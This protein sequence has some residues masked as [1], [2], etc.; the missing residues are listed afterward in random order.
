M[1][2]QWHAIDTDRPCDCQVGIVSYS[3]KC[4][5]TLFISE[6]TKYN[7]VRGREKPPFFDCDKNTNRY[8]RRSLRLASI[9]NPPNVLCSSSSASGSLVKEKRLE[10]HHINAANQDTKDKGREKDGFFHCCQDDASRAIS[11]E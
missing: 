1:G 9:N 6:K 4:F 5:Q 7:F 3:C 10:I 11:K 2:V 8:V